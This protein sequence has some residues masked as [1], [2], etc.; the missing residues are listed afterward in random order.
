MRKFILFLLMFFLTAFL[1]KAQPRTVNANGMRLAYESFGKPKKGTILLIAGTGAQMT[2]Y[3]SSFCEKIAAMG[4]QVIR[5]DNRDVGLST[6]LNKLGMPDWA[7]VSKAIAEKIPP[8]LPYSLD[9][10]AADA[11]GLLDALKIKKA[12]IVGASQ[13]A[14]IAQ[15]IAYLHP[16]HT[17]SLVSIMSGGGHTNFPMVA[18]PD[19][20]GKIP[21]PAAK[22]DTLANLKREVQTKIILA[23]KRYPID[24]ALAVTEAKNDIKRAYDPVG[25][26]RHGAAALAAFYAGRIKELQSV[27]VPTLVIHGSEDPLVT[28]DAGRDV[29]SL[30][31]GARFVLID[32]MGHDFPQPLFDKLAGLITENAGKAGK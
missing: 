18:K 11:T 22:E 1:A 32:G 23:G 17:L 9:D 7:A 29:A 8:P 20:V 10:M 4:Y 3:P 16:E 13:G 25:Q 24:S 5:F 28:V 27:K 30:I 15:R 6:H 31:P 19:V 26:L 12:H 2:M 14:L 21:P